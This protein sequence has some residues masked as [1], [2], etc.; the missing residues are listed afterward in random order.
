MHGP[1]RH[2]RVSDGGDV[3]VRFVGAQAVTALA[4]AP[5]AELEQ[6]TERARI[7]SEARLSE[8]TR[9]DYARCW[10]F[11]E[12][13]AEA[14]DV[15]T[16]PA[17]PQCIAAY[18][19]H[20]ADA[21]RRLSTIDQA[22]AAIGWK[23]RAARLDW[24][25]GQWPE[26]AQTMRG[27][28]RTV[29]KAKRRKAAIDGPLLERMVSRLSVDVPDELQLRAMLTVGWFGG[30]RRIEL[31]SLQRPHVRLQTVA[32][33][34]WVKLHLPRRKN[35]QAAEGSDLALCEQP[36]SV[37][38][39]VR[40]LAAWLAGKPAVEGP[41]FTRSVWWLLRS[42]QRLATEL[43]LDGRAYGGHSLRAGLVTH[44]ALAGKGIDAIVRQTGHR[45]HRQV[46]DYIRPA[47][48]TVGNVTEG[49]L[50]R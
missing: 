38:C 41:V 46:L 1:V 11:F 32:G 44:A 15:D 17:S 45:D 20:L 13:W 33:V 24:Y 2:G 29:G 14:L 19:T 9:E 37:A 25:P 31:V 28:R 12:R 4:L 42:I 34:Q 26:L 22:L 50:K 10:R 30:L 27:I 48:N 7:Y 16:L 36:A 3:W 8:R 43:G 40:N 5:S 39:P 6:L 21:G 35:D 47:M 49:I 18:M 23:H